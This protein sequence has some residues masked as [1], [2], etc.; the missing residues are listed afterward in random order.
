MNPVAKSLCSELLRVEPYKRLGSG[1]K[2]S[3]LSYEALKKHEFFK[4]VDFSKLNTTRPPIEPAVLFKL[5]SDRKRV[6]VPDGGLESSDEEAIADGMEDGSPEAK[7]APASPVIMRSAEDVKVRE[8]IVEKKCGWI[9]YKKRKLVLTSRPRLSY[10]DSSNGVY[11]VCIS[12]SYLYHLGG[13][14]TD[15]EGEGREDGRYEVQGGDSQS[16][17]LLRRTDEGGHQ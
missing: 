13:C 16:D 9:F 12:W 1:P 2:G 3:P 6:V 10:H 5:Q 8:G 4:G 15:E 17:L 14:A 7:V 11:K